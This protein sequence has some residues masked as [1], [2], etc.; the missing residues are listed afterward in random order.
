MPQS[1]RTRLGGTDPV[2]AI[3]FKPPGVF[4]SRDDLRKPSAADWRQPDPAVSEPC[5]PP[6]STGQSGGWPR[7][8]PRFEAVAVVEILRVCDHLI[9]TQLQL[10]ES[11]GDS[12]EPL[13][14]FM[15]PRN[16]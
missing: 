10:G 7:C 2:Q 11:E 9:N 15:R 6:V 8:I 13:Q 5:Q 14:R 12:A 4:R 16:R 1:I 3:G